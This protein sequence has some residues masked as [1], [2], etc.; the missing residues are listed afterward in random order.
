MSASALA[1]ASSAL[2]RRGLGRRGYPGWPLPW[3]ARNWNPGAAATLFGRRCWRRWQPS[4]AAIGRRRWLRPSGQPPDQGT[5]T[6][7][8]SSA[9]CASEPFATIPWRRHRS[10]ALGSL[11]TSFFALTTFAKCNSLP[12]SRRQ[13]AACARERWRPRLHD[14]SPGPPPSAA[15]SR[16]PVVHRESASLI[17]LNRR[18]TAVSAVSLS[19]PGIVCRQLG[20]H[21]ARPFNATC[22]VIIVRRP[23]RRTFRASPKAVVGFRRLQPFPP[24]SW[25]VLA[26]LGRIGGRQ[27][28]PSSLAACCRVAGGFG[29]RRCGRGHFAAMICRDQ[30]H[31]QPAREARQD[32]LLR[33]PNPPWPRLPRPCA[34]TLFGPPRPSLHPAAS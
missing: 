32:G 27:L 33:R 10:P 7:A 17:C 18:L 1:E 19:R 26:P 25:A 16:L 12:C 24:S 28:W 34:S 8:A 3:P 21:L 2:C 15:A 22:S 14:R 23:C 6:A 9:S 30:R 13:P 11:G 29:C 5:S 31:R 4:R 20:R